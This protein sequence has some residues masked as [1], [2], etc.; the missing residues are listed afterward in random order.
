M[1]KTDWKSNIN[2]FISGIKIMAINGEWIDWEA[3]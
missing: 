2:T 3:A 1:L